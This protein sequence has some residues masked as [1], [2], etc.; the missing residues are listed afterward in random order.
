M[1]DS[2]PNMLIHEVRALAGDRFPCMNWVAD[3]VGISQY[4]IY[5]YAKTYNTI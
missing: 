2:R 5:I 4:E 3:K 1:V